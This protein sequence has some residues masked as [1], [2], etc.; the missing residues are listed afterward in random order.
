MIDF[1]TRSEPELLL[2][3]YLPMKGQNSSA[4]SQ[5]Q[6]HPCQKL[7]LELESICIYE[8]IV[9]SESVWKA[10]LAFPHYFFLQYINTNF[11]KL[12]SDVSARSNLV[13]HIWCRFTKYK[14]IHL[15]NLF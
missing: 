9:V 12:L 4:L 6:L 11:I 1:W 10:H 5:T 3:V 2:T 8:S 14:I 7:I 15:S 13:K